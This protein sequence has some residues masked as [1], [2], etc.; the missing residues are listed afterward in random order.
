DGDAE[1][2][3]DCADPSE[4]GACVDSG[5]PVP[6]ELAPA[7]PLEAG[8]GSGVVQAASGRA[9]QINAAVATFL[10]CFFIMPFRR[11]RRQ[12]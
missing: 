12:T 1:P 5:E 9:A 8:P 11:V 6:F 7:D 3:E 10:K 4:P 2:A